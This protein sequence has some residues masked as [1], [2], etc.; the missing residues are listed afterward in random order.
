VLLSG[1]LQV[2]LQATRVDLRKVSA[3]SIGRIPGD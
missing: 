1:G 2:H 3:W